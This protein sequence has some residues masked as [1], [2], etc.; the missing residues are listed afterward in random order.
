MEDWAEQRLREH[1]AGW[2]TT[3]S[4]D[5]QPQSTPVWFL[6][7]GSTFLV[8]SR[9]DTPKLRNIAANPKVS[10][11]LDGQE[12]GVHVV[13]VEGTAEVLRDQPPADQ[14]PAYLEKYRESIA[15]Y[16]W[17][18]ASFAADY[19]VPVRITPTRVQTWE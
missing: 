16:D 14:V 7:D 5:G 15:G 17:T 9:P 8:Y 19:S 3:V 13:T 10:F 12:E 1:I 11:H 6:W 2:L 4:P 18:P